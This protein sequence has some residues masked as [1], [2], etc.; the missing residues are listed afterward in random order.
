MNASDSADIERQRAQEARLQAVWEV[1]KGWRYWLSVNNSQVGVWYTLTAFAFFLFAGV[2]ALLMRVQL[3]LPGNDFLSPDT[4]NQAFTLHGSVMMFLFAVPI[5]EAF[6]ILILPQMLMARDLPFPRLSAYGYWSFLIGGVFVCGSIFFGAAPDGGWFMYPPLATQYSPGLGPDIWMLGLSF[7]EVA[8]IAAAVELMV[9]ILKCRPPGMR[10]HMMPL[11]AWYLL[12]VAGMILF[13]F[14]PLIVGDLLFEFER[15]LDWPFFDPSRGGDPLLWQHLFWIFGHPEVYI[16]F[17]PAIGLVAMIVP[18]F[19]RTPLVGYT[20]IV[21]AA[22]GTGFISFGLWVH[23]MFTTGMPGISLAFFSAASEAVAIPTGV[24]IFCFLATILSGGF[25]RSVPM[26]YVAGALAIFV[27]GGLTGVMVALAPFD[28]QA[29]DTYFVVAHLHYVLIG[30]M[31]F[32]IIAAFHYFFPIAANR[33]LSEKLGKIAFWFMFVGFNVAFLPMHV[34]GLAGMQRRVYTYAPGIG[35]DA[36]NLVSTIGSFV[37]AFGIAIFVWDMLWPWGRKHKPV[38]NNPWK[39]GTLEWA[40]PIPNRDWG[41]RSIPQIESRYPLWDQPALAREVAEG[42][43]YLADAPEGKR[44]TLVT[45]TI[46]AQPVQCLRT[47]GPTAISM[48]AAAA[49]GGV[50]IFTTYHWWWAAGT[51]AVLALASILYWLWTGTALIP[52]QDEKDVG[53]GLRLPI[54]VSGPTSAG[55]WA[56]FITLVGD[57]T[58]FASLVF[59]YFFYWTL[60]ADFPPR[61]IAGPGLLWPLTGAACLLSAWL[62][63][64][65]AR[66]FNSADRAAA[67]YAAMITAALL[68]LAGLAALLAAPLSHDMD[69]SAHVYP[70]VV[71]L[72]VIWAGVHIAIGLVM[73]LYC[74]ARRA[75]GRMT[76]RYDIDIHNVTLYWHFLA[77]TIFVTVAVIAGFP[78]LSV[79]TP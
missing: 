11:Y 61:D 59:G 2:L 57:M 34:T 67:Y 75:A 39:A 38:P 65:A 66:A 36:L 4:Y 48:I 49:T 79:S 6:S 44:E 47:P 12:V 21:L 30:G 54:Y 14:P 1:A 62:L 45:T 9:G 33:L 70:A 64:I 16:V 13:A 3:A 50:F 5:F 76:A 37:L 20:W 56:M 23:H 53:R 40:E 41:V 22:V 27:F 26:L 19:A 35:F 63:V 24:Q 10:I 77:I 69:P 7:I 72:M 78:E 55:W 73:L 18:T 28:F 8:S 46:D 29:H 43:W 74:I 52:E 68:S 42:R 15:L 25:V 58:A 51:S 31:V 60:H 71:W 17:L 32:P